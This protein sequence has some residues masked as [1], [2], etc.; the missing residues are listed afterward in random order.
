MRKKLTN[1]Y[2]LAIQSLRS[3]GKSCEEISIELDLDLKVIQNYTKEIDERQA[4]IDRINKEHAEKEAALQGE[5]AR[6]NKAIDGVIVDKRV[7]KEAGHVMT[8]ALSEKTDGVN[9]QTKPP[10]FDDCIFRP[11]PLKK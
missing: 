8:Q 7:D 6:Q 4:L 3:N 11:K 5:I 1:I 9:F 2:K 10:H